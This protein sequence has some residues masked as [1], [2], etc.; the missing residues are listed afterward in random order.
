MDVDINVVLIDIH[1]HIHSVDSWDHSSI[2]KSL[3]SEL[4]TDTHGH[5]MDINICMACGNENPFFGVE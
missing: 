5:F 1:L 3:S 4:K 2:I